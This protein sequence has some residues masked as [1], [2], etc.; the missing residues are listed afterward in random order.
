MPWLDGSVQAA[1]SAARVAVDPLA[2]ESLP[3]GS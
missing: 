3:G 2:A 1:E